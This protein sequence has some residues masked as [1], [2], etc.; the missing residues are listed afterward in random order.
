MRE[1]PSKEILSTYPGFGKDKWIRYQFNRSYENPYPESD[2]DV[3]LC[4]TGS[5]RILSIEEASNNVAIEL[6]DTYKNLYVAMSGGIDSE[7]VAKTFHRLG[8]PFTPIIY[9]AGNLHSLD[10]WWAFKWCEENGY[11]PI[12]Y[13]EYIHEFIKQAINL[14]AKLCTRTSSGPVIFKALSDYVSDQHGYLITGGGFIEYFPDS[15][16]DYMT[17]RFKDIKV[18]D[19]DGNVNNE[20]WIW[21][22]PDLMH[23][24]YSCV[25]HPFNFLSWNPEIVLSYIAA[26]EPNRTSEYN[27]AKIFDCAARPKNVGVL[28]FL[29]SSSPAIRN[30]GA[31]RNLIG[32]SEMD[33][34]GSTSEMINLL[35]NGL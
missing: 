3:Y 1:Y 23:A 25:D 11:K 28:Q 15:N 30:W 34:L 12:V 26:R 16:L 29:W 20:G 8:I 18:V 31:L 10:T 19:S 6:Y 7:W 27:K 35:S 33:Y 32:N 22:E 13:N 14:S 2:M 17:S 24:M 5:S 4:P 21:H 9:E